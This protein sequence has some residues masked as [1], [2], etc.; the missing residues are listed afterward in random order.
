MNIDEKMLNKMS[1]H[2]IQQDI[3]KK[4]NFAKKKGFI[5]EMLGWQY[6][7]N[8]TLYFSTLT[9]DTNHMTILVVV[10]M[11]FNLVVIIDYGMKYHCLS[12]IQGI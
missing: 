6:S 4:T 5:P 9:K 7:K 2:W 1:A 3:K 8:Q 12:L 11:T 10:E